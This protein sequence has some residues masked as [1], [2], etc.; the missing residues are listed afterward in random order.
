MKRTTLLLTGVLI[1]VVLLIVALFMRPPELIDPV[2]HSPVLMWTPLP[3]PTAG[4]WMEHGLTP[5][6][7]QSP[8]PTRTV[9]ATKED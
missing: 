4:W 3:Q 8:T 9:A 5:V 7:F 1:G 6:P 2:S